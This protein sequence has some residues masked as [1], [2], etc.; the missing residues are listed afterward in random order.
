MRRLLLA[1]V[2][3][4]AASV[5]ISGPDD[6]VLAWMYDYGDSAPQQCAPAPLPPPCAA[7]PYGPGPYPYGPFLYGAN[8]LYGMAKPPVYWGTALDDTRR[9]IQF[10]DKSAGLPIR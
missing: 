9:G 10:L 3:L 1:A 2:V 5:S 7:G 4:V 8:H 6:S